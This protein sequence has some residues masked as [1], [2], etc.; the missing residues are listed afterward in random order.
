MDLVSDI[1]IENAAPLAATKI[2]A[3][4]GKKHHRP[5]D[6]CSNCGAKLIG[7]FCHECGQHGHVHR[8]VPH[9]IEELLHGITHFDSR[10]WRSLPMLVFRPGTLTRNYV[11]GQRTRYVAPFAMFLFSIFTMFLVFGFSGGPNLVS[12][13]SVTKAERVQAARQRVVDMEQNVSE[14]QT[15]I[16]D[17]E[18]ELVTLQAASDTG[19]GDIEATTGELSGA[20]G[21]LV[22]AQGQVEE[23][24]AALAAELA[25]PEAASTQEAGQSPSRSK[26]GASLTFDSEKERQDALAKIASEK[27]RAAEAGNKVEERVLAA[28]EVA[29]KRA[30]SATSGVPSKEGTK[31]EV[32]I[33]SDNFLLTLKDSMRRG[34]FINTS[35]PALDK[36]IADKTKNPD[37]F[38]YKLQNTSYKFSFLLMPLSMPFIWLMLFWKKNVTLYDH[39]VFSLYSLSFVSVL[40]MM[41]SLWAHW[42]SVGLAFALAAFVLPVHIFFQFKGAYQ[43]KWFS[44]LWRT[45]LFCGFFSWIVILL[46]FLSIIALGVT[47]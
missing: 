44:A 10:T 6:E 25:K 36:K 13:E 47:G 26:I 28:A 7:E 19:P 40:F 42:Y 39:A 27:A 14:A 41:I 16:V 17:L 4:R 29:A 1:N 11:M 21:Q 35:W 9:V 37:L 22:R 23:A 15:E 2:P 5:N 32:T 8:S 18:K 43:L 30:P 20:R 12:G 45:I 24:K 31:A 34:D 33:D 46:F 3:K 38:L